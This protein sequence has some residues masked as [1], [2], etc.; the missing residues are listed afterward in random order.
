VADQVQ[1]LLQ[2]LFETDLQAATV[3]TLY[4]TQDV[5]LQLR[6]KLWRELHP[7]TRVVSH[8]FSMGDWQPDR[9][10][11]MTDSAGLVRTIYL[12]RIGDSSAR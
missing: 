6:P 3:V 4:L 8:D 2:D 9:V 1:F 12:W 11:R 10:E 5:N 7:G